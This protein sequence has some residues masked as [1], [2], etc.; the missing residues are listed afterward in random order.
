MLYRRDAGIGRGARLLR[1]DERHLSLQ[2]SAD[3]AS[4]L[5]DAPIRSRIQGEL[6]APPVAVFLN[7]ARDVVKRENAF[8]APVC[9]RTP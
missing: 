3:H 9:T 1:T 4:D 2:R 6:W 8:Q 5:R 7:Y